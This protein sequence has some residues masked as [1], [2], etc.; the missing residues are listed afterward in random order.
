MAKKRHI[1]KN[2]QALFRF[3]DWLDSTT[4]AQLEWVMALVDLEKYAREH[5]LTG[6]DLREVADWLDREESDE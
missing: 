1:V 2:K 3:R 4:T 6:D 5:E